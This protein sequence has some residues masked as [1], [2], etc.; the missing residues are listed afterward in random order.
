MKGYCI[1][2]TQLKS[3]PDHWSSIGVTSDQRRVMERFKTETAA[4]EYLEENYG[5]YESDA[6]VEP[7]RMLDIMWSD[8]EAPEETTRSFK[9][10]ED[11]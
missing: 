2:E 5:M 6:S 4:Q 9:S 1:V 10:N 11:E 8:G 7:I 3:L